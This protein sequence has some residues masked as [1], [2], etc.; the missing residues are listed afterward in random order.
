MILRKL[1]LEDFQRH[2]RKVIKFGKITAITGPTDSGKSS[3]LR[4]LRW[5][6]L[7][8]APSG[9]IRH[10]AKFARATVFIGKHRISRTRSKSK[11]TY[12]L[13]GKTYKA[14]KT[15]I[16]E[17][18]KKILRLSVL[19]FQGQYDSPF[20]FDDSKI[21]VSNQLNQIVDLGVIDQTLSFAG[22]EVRKARTREEI[23]RER[24]GEGRRRVKSL[25]WAR[26]LGA[27]LAS[28]NELRGTLRQQRRQRK[29]LR[30]DLEELDRLSRVTGRKVPSYTDL[31][32][33]LEEIRRLEGEAG[34]LQGL[35]DSIDQLAEQKESALK[36]KC[37]AELK[38]HD[39]I[40]GKECPLCHQKIKKLV[41]L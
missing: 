38:F 18:I 12:S 31:D 40:L 29:E 13:D 17:P 26:D 11:N 22:R 2:K 21:Q 37:S 33:D 4:A 20:W 24:L 23:S 34:S 28:L 6:L 3:I 15:D 41:S 10:G 25:V 19:N 30:S 9:I 8:R 32:F 5:V 35:L 39:K 16:P 7:N 36:L 1:I 27:E 14:F